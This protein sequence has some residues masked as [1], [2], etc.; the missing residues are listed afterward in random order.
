MTRVE[1]KNQERIK[2]K[3]KKTHVVSDAIYRQKMEDM[4]IEIIQELFGVVMVSL[5]QEFGWF[6]GKFRTRRLDRFLDRFIL[7]MDAHARGENTLEEFNRQCEEFGVKHEVK[8]M[9]EKGGILK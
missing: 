4:K 8:S 6:S 9:K 2:K 3:Q 1:R 5:T 7:N